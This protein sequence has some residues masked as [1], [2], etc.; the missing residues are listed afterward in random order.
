M[1]F[2][3]DKKN[4]NKIIEKD[5]FYHEKQ[6]ILNNNTEDNKYISNYI[7]KHSQ[8]LTNN[9]FYNFI[10]DENYKNIKNDLIK[11]KIFFFSSFINSCKSYNNISEL[12]KDIEIFKSQI[13]DEDYYYNIIYNYLKN[14]FELISEKHF[15]E[16]EKNY[17]ELLLII[18]KID[19]C[20]SINNNKYYDIKNE[21]IIIEEKII[22]LLRK[23][24]IK[25]KFIEKII[26]NTIQMLEQNNNTIN[27]SNE[28]K[29]IE[30]NNNIKK[31]N[32]YINLIKNN[33]NYNNKKDM[34][35]SEIPIYYETYNKNKNISNF[36]NNKNINSHNN[37]NKNDC[38]SINN[39]QNFNNEVINEVK[40][41]KKNS[42]SNN[43]ITKTKK[44]KS[45]KKKKH[46]INK[47]E[48][49]DNN[50][51][52]FNYENIMCPPVKNNID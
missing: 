10:N 16:E 15:F 2:E 47:E 20:L 28:K 29:Y 40:H 44:S 21:I 30:K 25:S 6:N 37:K 26:N 50:T 36:D 31:S 14:V 23:N 51:I 49:Q 42:I 34:K 24:N 33:N 5:S 46:K 7:F 38:S 32:E 52:T 22:K 3:N 48:K 41:D 35:E 19:E 39:N 18:N 45:K 1:I 13:I 43:G 8:K 9:N 11:N 12:R 27:I 4:E 17:D